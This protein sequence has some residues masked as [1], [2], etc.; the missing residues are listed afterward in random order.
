MQELSLLSQVSLYV[1]LALIGLCALI[2]W[3][4]QVM[5]LKGKAMKKPDRSSDDWHE[6]KLPTVALSLMYFWPVL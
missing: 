4:W 1:L 6:Q 3:G 2:V 5:V